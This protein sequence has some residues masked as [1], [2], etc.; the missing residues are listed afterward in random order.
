MSRAGG[1]AP[2]DDEALA[3]AVASVPFVT[4]CPELTL[5]QYASLCV[6]I[7]FAPDQRDSIRRRYG[8]TSEAEHR[9]LDDRWRRAFAGQSGLLAAFDAAK[10]TYAAYKRAVEKK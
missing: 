2:P 6:D 1:T 3:R 5:K 9:T 10:A 8:V 7:D 4:P